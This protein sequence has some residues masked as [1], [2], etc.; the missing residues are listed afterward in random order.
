MLSGSATGALIQEVSESLAGRVG[1][2]QLNPFAV[3]ELREEPRSSFF[4]G[5]LSAR[6][7]IA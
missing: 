4:E 6:N 3:T 7:A 5:L 2:L 1:L